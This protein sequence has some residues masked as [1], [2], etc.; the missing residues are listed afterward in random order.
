MGRIRYTVTTTTKRCPHCGKVID[1]KAEGELTPLYGIIFLFAFYILI[2]YW[3][4]KYLAFKAPEVPSV[5]E[6]ITKCPHC[7]L[8]IRTDNVSIGELKSEA[9]LNYKFRVWFWVCYGL[10]AL[11]GTSLFFTLVSEASLASVGGLIALL[12]LLGT[13]AIIFVYRY[14]L[15]QCC[16][17]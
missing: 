11:F 16:S 17:K 6:K 12:S 1:Q 5:G 13:L 9:L 7:A 10:G 3:L 14:R 8:P 2:P 4:I 15:S